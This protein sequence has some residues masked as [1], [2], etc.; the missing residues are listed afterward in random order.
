MSKETKPEVEL[1][2]YAKFNP[3]TGE[4]L[5]TEE[6]LSKRYEIVQAQLET[7]ISLTSGK[8]VVEK[9]IKENNE[10]VQ[11]IE[12]V[13]QEG[14]HYGIIPNTK[15][16]CLFQAGADTLTKTYGVNIEYTLVDK[17]IDIKN[18]FIDYEYK[19]TAY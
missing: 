1:Q 12:G 8:D 2:G 16:K 6:A 17:T 9:A 18:N 10:I 5:T 15:N 13:F 3:Y 11:M 19:A 14:V 7:Q 4:A